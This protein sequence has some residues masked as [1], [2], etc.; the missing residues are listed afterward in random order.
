[1][2]VKYMPENIRGSF[3]I[4]YRIIRRSIK[5]PRLELWG[6]ELRIIIP[7]NANPLK[8]IRENRS[9]I[10]R[11]IE[12]VREARRI[13][14][15]LELVPRTRRKFKALVEKVAQEYAKMLG[16]KLG[17]VRIRKMKTCWGSCSSSGN[18][19]INRE[20]QYL[21]ENLI[22][23]LVYHE[24]CHLIRWSHDREFHKL[25]A[26]RFPDYRDLDLQL[27]A[28]WIKLSEKASEN[29]GGVIGSA[30]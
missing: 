22:R 1:M 15:K 29:R 19:T 18:I 30:N 11:Q 25:I 16:I 24:L 14:E 26:E 6:S 28:Y 17:K 9:W 21:P 20:A 23:Y 2:L 13:A 10:I 3:P 27:Q 5:H 8:V 12:F 4:R 7:K